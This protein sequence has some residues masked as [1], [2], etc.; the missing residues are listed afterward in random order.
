MLGIARNQAIPPVSLPT[1]G[2]N[3]LGGGCLVNPSN[4]N[5][6][7]QTSPPA[8]DSFYVPPTLSFNSTNL[9]PTEF[10]NGWTSVFSR[11]VVIGGSGAVEVQTG[12]GNT[13]FYSGT[14]WTNGF[15]PPSGG[16]LASPNSLFS[17]ARNTGPFTETQSD[18]TL[19]QYSSGGPPSYLVSIQNVAGSRWTLTRDSSNRVTQVTDPF[20][21]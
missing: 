5:L 14:G 10:G 11:S 7:L 20:R 6:L 17:A 3:S 4:G 18:G 2:C 21:G 12:A 19:F 16:N 15:Y 1:G 13:Y 8:G 9:T